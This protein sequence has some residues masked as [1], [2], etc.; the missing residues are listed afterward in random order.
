MRHFF[1]VFLLLLLSS[2]VWAQVANDECINATSLGSITNYCSNPGQFTN[3]GATGSALPV[4]FCFPDT[5]TQDVWFSFTATATNASIRVIGQ[6]ERESGGS[7][8]APQFVLYDASCTMPTEI[9]CASD[10]FGVNLIE[11]ITDDLQPGELYFLRV[12]ARD[13]IEGTFQLCIDLFDFVPE[14]KSDCVDGVILCDKSSFTVAS[15]QGGGNDVTEIDDASCLYNEFAPRQT[16]SGSVWY[17]W[18]CDTAGTL[19]LELRPTNPTDDLDFSVYELPGGIDD[20]AGKELLRCIASGENIGQPF[21]DWERCTGVTGLREGDGDDTEIPG[22]QVGDN[23][24]G[25]ALQ[26]EAGKSYAMIVNNFSQTGNGF[27]INF[28]GSGTFQGPKPAFAIDP[29]TGSQCDNDVITFTN[30]STLTPGA[31]GSYDW[32]FGSFA[33]RPQASGN[34][35]FQITYNSFGEKVITLRVT[36]SEGCVVTETREIFIEPCCEASTPLI[37][38][39]PAGID[40]VCAGTATGS[41]T[42][43][44]LTGVP[45]FVY[46]INGGPFLSDTAYTGLFADEYTIFVQNIKGCVDTVYVELFDPPATEVEIGD[47]L[48][49]ELGERIVVS[50]QTNIAGPGTYMWSG[51]DSLLCLNPECSEVEIIA[52]NPAE[53]MVFFTSDEGCVASD[54]LQIDVRKVRPL[55][56]PNAFSPNIDGVNDNWTIYGPEGIVTRINSVQVFDRWGNRVWEASNLPLNDPTVGWDGRFRGEALN[57]AVFAFYAEVEYV[58]GVVLPVTGDIN[59]IR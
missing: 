2:P 11:A 53:L 35:P 15:L 56:V 20:C 59:L 32:F 3:V 37:A 21:S 29:E 8:T 27:T 50:A 24:F 42:T 57:P 58:D 45:D 10:G 39:E 17:R 26:M 43:S 36:S 54:L 14:P 46:S 30:Q 33:D 13:Q 6:L 48:N 25:E 7:I 31:S 5:L 55:Y 16:E 4:P 49:A 22:C 44:V 52:G 40:P 1:Q 41:F 51:V 28:T 19:G 34:G 38:A 12:A 23:N 47:N 18:T 9:I